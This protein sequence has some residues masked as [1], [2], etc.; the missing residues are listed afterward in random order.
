MAG[1]VFML[2]IYTVDRS[3]A[4][5][6]LRIWIGNHKHTSYL[7]VVSKIDRALVGAGRINHV[8]KSADTRTKFYNEPERPVSV[9]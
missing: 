9:Q 1:D 4:L 8:Y 3:E 2:T 7:A 6:K 5:K